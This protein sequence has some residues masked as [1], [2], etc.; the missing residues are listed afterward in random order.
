[1]SATLKKIRKP[2]VILIGL[3][4]FAA[5]TGKSEQTEGLSRLPMV[6]CSAVEP[7]CFERTQK[8]LE[9]TT[10]QISRW[11]SFQSTRSLH[12]PIGRRS[13]IGVVIL[14]GL[15]ATASQFRDLSEKMVEEGY[16]VLHLSHPGHWGQEKKSETVKATD[17]ID[18]ASRAIRIAHVMAEKV[19][20]LGH[21]MGGM[22]AIN[23]ALNRSYHV[24]G[25]IAME[26][27]VR[28]MPYIES[29]LCRVKHFG[30]RISDVPRVKLLLTGEGP[31]EADEYLSLSMGCE[32]SKLRSQMVEKFVDSSWNLAAKAG[33]VLNAGGPLAQVQN[34]LIDLK[35]SSLLGEQMKVPSLFIVNMSDRIVQTKD[36]L[37]LAAGI[38]HKVAP[39][40]VKIRDIVHGTLT[41]SKSEMVEKE[42]LEFIKQ[43]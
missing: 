28:V 43:F 30:V 37:A 4:S 36:T 25:L 12:S 41:N 39:K 35:L 31:S 19:I 32:V 6:A 23:F 34:A 9:N 26:P 13:R 38:P 14:P 2:I 10:D 21:S 40:I 11:F 27:A 15:F 16:F 29:L 1:M 24:D 5:S 7:G 3:A 8:A 22:L 20:L 42:T 18:E 33:A 17:W